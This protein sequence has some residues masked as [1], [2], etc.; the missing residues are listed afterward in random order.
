MD[1]SLII[2]FGSH[3]LEILGREASQLP[4][5]LKNP[6]EKVAAGTELC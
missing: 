3:F 4:P 1:S 2:G 5:R 6:Y